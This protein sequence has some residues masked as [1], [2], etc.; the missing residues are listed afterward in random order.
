MA[1]PRAKS[2]S[3]PT[4]RPTKIGNDTEFGLAAYFYSRDIG[5]KVRSWH[6]PVVSG[7]DLGTAVIGGT[8]DCA[9]TSHLHA[10]SKM[11]DICVRI[12]H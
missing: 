5:R 11:S 12:M 2:P 3:R 9:L 8:A 7:D 6:L 4:P 10:S 1:S